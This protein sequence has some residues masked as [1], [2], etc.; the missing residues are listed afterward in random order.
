[1]KKFTLQDKIPSGFTA[2][3]R[4]FDNFKVAQNEPRVVKFRPVS[5]WFAVAAVL[6][7]ALSI[8]ALKSVT[9]PDGDSAAIEHYLVYSNLNEDEIIRQLDTEDL[10]ALASEYE[11]EISVTEESIADENYENL[12]Y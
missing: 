11:L 4:Y 5:R 8:P 2:P 3:D 7:L 6:V 9:A 12:I 1:M 10:E